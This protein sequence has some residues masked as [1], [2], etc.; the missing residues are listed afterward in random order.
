MSEGSVYGIGPTV[1]AT[2]VAF[3]VGYAV[4]AW[5]LKYLER[6]SFAPFVIYRIALG[7]LTLVLLTTGTLTA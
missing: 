2:V 1:L 5:L 6:G 3:V 7:A 4:V